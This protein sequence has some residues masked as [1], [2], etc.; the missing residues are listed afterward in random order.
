MP[1]IGGIILLIY[2]NSVFIKTLYL[3]N[4]IKYNIFV[5]K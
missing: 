2:Q 5:A 1:P 3:I 4:K